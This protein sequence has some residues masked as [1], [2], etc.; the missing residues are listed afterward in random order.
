MAMSKHIMIVEDESITQQ[1]LKDMLVY[2]AVE[3]I[4]C[5]DNAED[6]FSALKSSRCEMILMDINIKGSTDGIQFARKILQ[7][8]PLPIIFI[9]AHS[10]EVTIQEA[11]ELSPYGFITKPFSVSHL[12][13]TLEAAYTKSLLQEKKDVQ[14]DDL[15]RID[16]H[17]AYSKSLKKLYKDDQEIKLS[18]KHIK[19]I[20]ILCRNIDHTV[21]T[22]ILRSE[23]WGNSDKAESI[24]RTLVYSL[25]KQLPDLPLVSYSKVGYAMKRA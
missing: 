23:I 25:R 2:Y 20:D 11:L 14:E 19:L 4:E 10:D 18:S 6:A 15:L 5:Y 3:T 12:A 17:Y 8:K 7:C 1:C 9:S 22:A 21:D 13:Q 16:T 24:L